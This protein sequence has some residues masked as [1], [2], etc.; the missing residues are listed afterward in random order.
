[1]S[2]H[3]LLHRE[4]HVLGGREA[5]L[6]DDVLERRLDLGVREP[7]REVLLDDREL[8]GLGVDQILAPSA[9]VL[10][11]R[12]AALLDGAAEDR[13]RTRPPSDPR[14]AWIFSFFSAASRRRSV[15]TRGLSPA[16][17]ADFQVRFDARLHGVRRLSPRARRGSRGI[18]F[19]P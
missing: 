1:M 5:L 6:P 9:G 15:A 12:V 13:L 8:A 4:P 3:E 11:D 19:A 17:I 18:A 7:L 16:F 10:L 14:W 2:R